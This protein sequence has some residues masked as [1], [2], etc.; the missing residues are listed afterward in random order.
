M[1]KSK[2]ILI[3][4]VKYLEY[5]MRELK[6]RYIP[7]TTDIYLKSFFEAK[8]VKTIWILDYLS[9]SETERVKLDISSMTDL[10]IDKLDE[11][12]S[13]LYERVFGERRIRFFYSTM[14]Y[15][16]KRFLISS[17]QF[18]K[19]LESIVENT[20]ITELTYLHDDSI[21][22][23]CGN[24]EQNA[25]FFPDDIAWKLMRYWD[26]DK[27]PQMVFLKVSAKNPLLVEARCPNCSQIIKNY[28]RPIK[29]FLEKLVRYPYR[30]LYKYSPSKRTLLLL[31]PLYD[32]SFMLFSLR[33]S[34]E[35]N[36]VNWDIDHNISPEFLRGQPV[37]PFF[38]SSKEEQIS[39]IN[40]KEIIDKFEF[41]IKGLKEF[42]IIKDLNFSPFITS[43]IKNFL[44][45]KLLNI[46]RYWKAIKNFYK[47]T[48]IDILF[49]GN[50]PHRY[51]AGIVTEFCR[52]NK[53]PIVGM[54]H[55]GGYVSNFAGR[56][57]FDLDF[58]KCDFWF[59]YGFNTNDL[60]RAY[61]N[62]NKYPEIL[63]VGSTKIF[64]L[65]INHRPKYKKKPKVKVLYPLGFFMNFFWKAET[66]IPQDELFNLQKQIID[67]LLPYA[68]KYR[69]ILKFIP[70]ARYAKQPLKPYL[71]SLGAH[72]FEIVDSV[73]YQKV[74]KKYD[75]DIILLDNRSTP[76]NESLATES[77]IIVYNDQDKS[78]FTENAANLLS[79]RAFVCNSKEE[80][81]D[82]LEKC[83]NNRMIEKD[84]E[85]REFLEKYCIYKGDPKTYII[86]AIADII[87][88]VEY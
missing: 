16:F 58:E 45:K 76:L 10:L 88:K 38:A 4:N 57:H 2:Y 9:K 39:D 40:C 32:L 1:G 7:I 84:L 37:H 51:P 13:N 30:Y 65:A 60:K 29:H 78:P 82:Q 28:L 24:L 56:T 86:R 55:G 49:W 47:T 81:L 19:G 54:Q 18:L 12:N 87:D 62:E 6:D 3:D 20:N 22:F 27:K 26:Y 25:F 23:L 15:L 83:L 5:F 44:E 42:T 79:K 21:N 69:V 46:I 63:P 52:L 80:F 17:F 70:G 73:S 72:N 43:L 68:N 41:N 64:D 48:K 77:N 33:M 85:N 53:I 31:S 14:K 35:Y 34:K 59:S 74:L 67:L 36:V 11:S 71:N 61:P 8:G 66:L 50:P 75:A